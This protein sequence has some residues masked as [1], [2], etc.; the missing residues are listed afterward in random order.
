MN[1]LSFSSL[2]N[3]YTIKSDP[4][5]RSSLAVLLKS[6]GG[7]VKTPFKALLGKYHLSVQLCPDAFV[8]DQGV[9]KAVYLSA[10]HEFN[11][12]SVGNLAKTR[13]LQ[14][15]LSKEY[16]NKM[17]VKFVC[18]QDF[19]LNPDFYI[20]FDFR[21]QENE[22]YL[23]AIATNILKTKTEFFPE[24]NLR[25]LKKTNSMKNSK[26]LLSDVKSA[27][28]N[29][30]ANDTEKNTKNKDVISLGF[31]LEM[32]F[33]EF[34]SI[35]EDFDA[36]QFML[37][38]HQL[39]FYIAVLDKKL[40]V[41]FD[42]E[43]NKNVNNLLTNISNY[44]ESKKINKSDNSKLF[45]SGKRIAMDAIPLREWT[46]SLGLEENAFDEQLKDLKERGI[47]HPLLTT[48]N[49]WSYEMLNHR[50]FASPDY[51]FYRDW[52]T[53][54]KPLLGETQLRSNPNKQILTDFSITPRTLVPSA[55]GRSLIRSPSVSMNWDQL[56]YKSTETKQKTALEL[57]EIVYGAKAP[58]EN[59]II[60]EDQFKLALTNMLWDLKLSS[61]PGDDLVKL[62]NCSFWDKLMDTSSTSLKSV[63]KLN[64]DPN[65]YNSSWLDLQ[66]QP[67][68][69]SLKFE[70]FREMKREILKWRELVHDKIP[71]YFDKAKNDIE[72][73]EI[74]KFNEFA[75][76][77][78]GE[79][80][81]SY[82]K[83][84]IRRDSY[85]NSAD[86]Q[87]VE[88]DMVSNLHKVYSSRKT[89]IDLADRLLQ[90][91]DEI[92]LYSQN[93]L[94]KMAMY[95]RKRAKT[96]LS[97]SEENNVNKWENKID[98]Q[99]F[100]DYVCVY[101]DLI[102]CSMQEIFSK[103]DYN[104]ISDIFPHAQLERFG[105]FSVSDFLTFL[106]LGMSPT[107]IDISEKISMAKRIDL[108]E[109]GICIDSVITA[110]LPLFNNIGKFLSVYTEN[111]T[112][113]LA[114]NFQE[115][116]K[117]DIMKLYG[118]KKEKE[119]NLTWTK[120]DFISFSEYLDNLPLL[121][122]PYESIRKWI[123][124]K[125]KES[126]IRNTLGHGEIKGLTVSDNQMRNI[127]LNKTKNALEKIS[128][129]IF[130]K[131]YE[132]V[133]TLELSQFT[134]S[135]LDKMYL[136]KRNPPINFFEICHF[137]LNHPNLHKVDKINFL[138]TLDV[139]KI[140]IEHMHMDQILA[141]FPVV[142]D[143]TSFISNREEKL[144]IDEVVFVANCAAV[145]HEKLY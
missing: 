112:S 12:D 64:I 30:F 6:L 94:M 49:P 17:E 52:E 127:L 83:D 34:D 58:V 142:H 66:H 85:L 11:A 114:S 41:N 143:E 53:M 45:I 126:R 144:R 44:L 15:V 19:M 132:N 80:L 36:D 98:D 109:K 31:H 32:L 23:S 67:S 100:D 119:H 88:R 141:E 69:Y 129:S 62:F 1:A 50:L 111:Y 101:P 125:E 97:E 28:K 145:P 121:Q 93:N 139:F 76:R 91:E 118:F 43:T 20:D 107:F 115:Q 99:L 104:M 140:D 59:V 25:N 29:I 54:F 136:I 128:L 90:N 74:H 81:K 87:D 24:N 116:E 10:A 4:I 47:T 92:R 70:K 123:E 16:G 21:F 9:V 103:D 63:D 22:E 61:S 102:D 48:E 130:N 5:R 73:E 79:L 40:R 38:L 72:R 95:S 60:K 33:N 65:I 75:K 68:L 8:T 27:L 13:W 2:E 120:A 14:N 37:K 56:V 89:D 35:S 39:Y 3:S 46:E 78:Y 18:L 71:D 57:D 26:D 51:F 84:F 134:E 42:Q 86:M 96:E 105:E 137:I 55:T 138:E 133:T 113:L 7:S 131:N 135:L 106:N 122:N 108:E 124:R 82:K 110:E 77:K 117:V